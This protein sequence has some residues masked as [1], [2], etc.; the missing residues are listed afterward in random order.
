MIPC[1]RHL[2]DLPEEV[3]YL[4]CAYMSPLL[5][6]AVR[7]G[8]AGVARKAR[9]WTIRAEDFFTDSE[10]ARG[11]FAG[12][13]GAATD[14][15]A[16]VP[17]ASYGIAVA[18][19]NLRLRPASRVVVLADQFPSNVL[20]WQRMAEAAGA[21]VVA[22]D[23]PV[24]E[25]LTLAVLARIDERTAVTALPHCRWTDGALLDLERI[26]RRCREVGSALVVDGTQSVGA[27]PFDV[28]RVRPDFLVV[29]SYKWLLGPYGL[30]FLYADPRHHEGEP[31]EHNWIAREGSEDFSRLVDYRAGFQKGARRFDMGE[32][33]SF[34]SM[35]IAIE[36]LERL[37]GW[38]VE[39]IAGTLAAMTAE[40]ARAAAELGL[41]SLPPAR[42]GPHFLG[43]RF[44]GEAPRDL[45][46]R[47]AREQV[48]ISLR[49]SS[50]R[51]TP[52]LYNHAG[53]RQRLMA[54]L[55]AA[56]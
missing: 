45:P 39:A 26:G 2:F 42:R 35:P 21:A 14:D 43:L 34:A 30:G 33:S 1:Q 17:A 6:E 47:L 3:A 20:V 11:L 23:A 9:P 27:L 52:H 40:I 55:R 16:I 31:L 51:V 53:D 32:R 25:D 7:A 50:L 44:P 15:V 10:R 56:L 48:H 4:N 49:G 54:V 18:A 24:D 41:S 5:R 46:E 29:A 28:R 38:G 36:A 12:L 37:Q 8:Q 22:V 13:I 19:R